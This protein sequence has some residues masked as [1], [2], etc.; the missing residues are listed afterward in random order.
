M[1][2]KPSDAEDEYF[3]LE[4]LRQLKRA[5]EAAARDTKEQERVEL[6]KLHWMHCPKCGLELAEIDFRGVAVDACFG[7]RGMFLDHGEIDKI[8]EDNEPGFLNRMVGT[9]FSSES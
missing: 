9:L 6:R 7:C 8:L 2:V 5:R 3:K 4:E 1:P